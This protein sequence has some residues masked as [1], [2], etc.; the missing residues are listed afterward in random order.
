MKFGATVSLLALALVASPVLADSAPPKQAGRWS[1]DYTGRKADGAVVFG[2]LANGL[3][4]AIMHNETP[5]D[6]VAMRMRIGS[7]SI[8]ERDEEQGLAHF[9]EHMAFRGSRNIADGDVVHML[10]RQGCALVPTPTPSPPRTRR[11]ICSPSPR[12]IPPRWIP[13]SPCSARSAS[14]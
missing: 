9:L 3:R 6:G 12:L 14:G 7:G 13:V 4:Y 8:V 10:E 11:C 2:T 5:S 1:Q